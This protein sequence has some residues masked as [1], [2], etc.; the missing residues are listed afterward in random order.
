MSKI[1]ITTIEY[2]KNPDRFADF[3]NLVLY[4]GEEVLHGSQLTAIDSQY[5]RT[6]K[7]KSNK[8]R[9]HTFKRYRDL[10]NNVCA[11]E[12]PH[13]ILAILALEPF[14]YVDYRYPVRAMFYD[15]LEYDR[16]LKCIANSNYNNPKVHLT[17]GG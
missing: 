16:Q 14:D 11:M 17:K 9:R 3:F 1:D 7:N 5:N 2:F 4:H 15:A 13:C 8:R 6:T 10:I 12:S